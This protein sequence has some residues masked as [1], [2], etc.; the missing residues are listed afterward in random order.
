MKCFAFELIHEK[1]LAF[2]ELVTQENRLMQSNISSLVNAK[3]DIEEMLV[4]NQ[5]K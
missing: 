2:K 5:N 3:K 1:A 4:H